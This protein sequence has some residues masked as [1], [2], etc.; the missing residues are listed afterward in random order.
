M[1]K[2]DRDIFKAD[3]ED[4]YSPVAHLILEALAI[5]T[6]SGVQKSIC[7]FIIRRTYAWGRKDDQISLREFSRACNSK[8]SYISA[9]L[10]K[11]LKANVIFRTAYQ[12][13]KTC[14]YM[15]NPKINEWRD[16]LVDLELLRQN[17]LENIY[18]NK[19]LTQNHNPSTKVEPLRKSIR[20]PLRK[21]RRVPFCKSGIPRAK[22]TRNGAGCGPPKYSSKYILN[23][24]NNNCSTREPLTVIFGKEISRQLTPLQIERIHSLEKDFGY[25]IVKFAMEHA[26]ANANGTWGIKF[27]ESILVNW[28]R[29]NLKTVDEIKTHEEKRRGGKGNGTSNTTG[30]ARNTRQNAVHDDVRKWDNVTGWG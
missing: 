14:S 18:K 16:G 12:P 8:E 9:Q 2:G 15:I 26:A 20:E 21:Y 22:K 5:S 29:C 24:Y 4:G 17:M 3:I 7:C 1:P 6:M 10:N 11:L 28:N 27:L 13:G 19:T 23:N 30:T 25:D